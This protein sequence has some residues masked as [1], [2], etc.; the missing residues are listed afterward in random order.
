MKLINSPES[1]NQ[2][3]ETIK[4]K[5]NAVSPSLGDSSEIGGTN[6]LKK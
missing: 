5:K 1:K 2:K 4:N 6:H 3:S